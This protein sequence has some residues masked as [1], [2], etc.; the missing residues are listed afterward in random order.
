MPKSDYHH[1]NILCKQ[2]KSRIQN[3]AFT[4]NE[5]KS[6]SSYFGKI[7]LL[8]HDKFKKIEEKEIEELRQQRI[9]DAKEK[10]S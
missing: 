7:Y 8:T 3:G 10:E 9:I 2:M 5:W 4:K 1:L 6:I